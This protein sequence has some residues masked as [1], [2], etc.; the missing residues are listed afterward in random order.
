MD[1]T[2][3]DVLCCFRLHTLLHPHVVAQTL[4]P[5]IFYLCA[6]RTQRLPTLLG[7]TKILR[8]FA[9]GFFGIPFS[10]H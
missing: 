8:L 9:Q 10:R 4:K 7:W 2:L 6:K 3:L 1:A 5:F